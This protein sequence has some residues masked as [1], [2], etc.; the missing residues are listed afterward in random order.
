VDGAADL[1]PGGNAMESDPIEI[2]AEFQWSLTPLN[3]GV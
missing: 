1:L 2:D 3:Y